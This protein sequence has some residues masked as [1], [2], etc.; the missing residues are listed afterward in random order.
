MWVWI[1]TLL[2]DN[3]GWIPLG[4]VILLILT[5]IYMSKKLEL[6]WFCCYAIVCLNCILCI[7]FVYANT[8][9]IYFLDQVL[10]PLV[11]S[12]PTT[13]TYNYFYFILNLSFLLLIP[14]ILLLLFFY[15][16][17][18]KYI[19]N[20]WLNI[21]LILLF[22]YY[23]CILFWIVKYDLFF[24]N[25]FSLAYTPEFSIAFD[26]Q[27][28]FEQFLNC[29]WVEYQEFFLFLFFMLFIPLT[30]IFY[31]KINYFSVGFVWLY[32]FF[33]I[34]FIFILYLFF[35][36]EFLNNFALY[37]TLWIFFLFFNFFWLILEK[38]K[39]YKKE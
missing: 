18:I 29:F 22:I 27:P 36:F 6:F 31:G 16:S 38:S 13:F 4:C 35:E 8:I 26:F 15:S 21:F 25:W 37:I 14:F 39:H 32:S 19:Y 30:L 23:I 11:V 28:N 12:D 1:L 24:S 33:F 17:S 10:E 2:I 9:L 7:L 20:S 3:I 34:Y 5:Y